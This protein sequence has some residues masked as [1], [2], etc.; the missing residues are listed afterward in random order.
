MTFLEMLVKYFS[1][2]TD[3]DPLYAKFLGVQFLGHM[4][5][6]NS[7]IKIT[8]DVERTNLYVALIGESFYGRKSVSQDII[9][10]LY[11]QEVLL[12]NETSAEKF[13]ANLADTPNG[14]WMNGEFS[15]ILKHINKGGYLSTVAEV[16]NDLYRYER[17]IYRREIMKESYEIRRPFPTFTTTLTTEVLKEI[18]DV[19]MLNGGLFGR[20]LF[21]PGSTNVKPRTNIPQEATD[22][23]YILKQGAVML[24]LS[25]QS[26][27]FI[28]S[29]DAL[30]RVNEIE[31]LLIKNQYRAI[32]GRYGQAM[33]KIAAILAFNDKIIQETDS[34]KNNI[35][36]N[37]SNNSNNDLSCYIENS[38]Y[39][40]NHAIFTIIIGE[41]HVNDA[42]E[43]IKPCI[44]LCQDVFKYVELNKKHIAKV[45]TYVQKNHPVL[46]S[47]VMRY[48]NIDKK[49]CEEAEKTLGDGGCEQLL[50]MYL[51]FPESLKT[52]TVYCLNDENDKCIDCSLNPMCIKRKQVNIN[53][54]L[55]EKNIYNNIHQTKTI[56]I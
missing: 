3:A 52:S 29:D 53:D 22:L 50:I 42:F 35:K 14:V 32:A 23:W 15:K 18:S 24:G 20:L 55:V 33:I 9:A 46:R 47:D 41:Q 30:I 17:E 36:S 40:A 26:Y 27:E 25:K 16:L 6:K 34:S 38:L 37:S 10:N 2:V 13:I 43:M 54:V 5:T 28:F 12:P 48:C 31:Q 51:K 44:S 49:Q 45:L 8:P 4:L 7:T 19:E 21:V 1:L 39:I 11:P 56:N